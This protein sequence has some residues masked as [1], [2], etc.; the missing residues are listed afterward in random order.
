LEHVLHEGHGP[1]DGR[2]VLLHR[3][4]QDHQQVRPRAEGGA[5]LVA[6]DERVV[7]ARVEQIERLL[8]GGE[9]EIVQRV[10]LRVELEAE[11]AVAEVEQRGRG[12]GVH[13]AAARAHV[14]EQELAVRA[15]HRPNAAR[16]EGALAVDALVEGVPPAREH[17]LHP[18]RHHA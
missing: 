8:V 9:D 4:H 12:V 2:P 7:P 13:L 14:V 3:P 18:R 1:L 15:R 16:V 10:H 17:V 5:A 6:D 11:H